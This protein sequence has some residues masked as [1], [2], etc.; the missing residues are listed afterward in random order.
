[1]CRNKK[2]ICHLF[3][4]QFGDKLCLLPLPVSIWFGIWKMN[5]FLCTNKKHRV[6]GGNNT[7]LNVNFTV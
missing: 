2:M 7:L 1:M 3:K 6:G 4:R 5:I